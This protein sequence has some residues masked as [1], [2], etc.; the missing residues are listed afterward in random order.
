MR[1]TFVTLSIF[2]LIWSLPA[3]GAAAAKACSSVRALY[4]ELFE[5]A[6]TDA[7]FELTA[8][9]A[10]VGREDNMTSAELVVDDGTC[11]SVFGSTADPAVAAVRP[12]DV[13]RATGTI[14]EKHAGKR[15]ADVTSCSVLR[16]EKP[17]Q[18]HDATI[19]EILSGAH[20]FRFSRIRAIV[21]DAS[22]SETN[23]YWAILGLVD[24]Q[25]SIALQMLIEHGGADALDSLVGQEIL[26]DCFPAPN[27]TGLFFPGRHLRTY[28][29]NNLHTVA[30]D[31]RILPVRPVSGIAMRR[32]SDFH[33][34]G[35]HSASGYVLATWSNNQFLLKTSEGK[36]LR[37]FLHGDSTPR[38]G[39]SVEVVGFP[40][41]DFFCVNLVN[42]TWRKTGS[43]PCD[44][45]APAVSPLSRLFTGTPGHEH[46][47][48]DLH[49]RLVRIRGRILSV[50]NGKGNSQLLLTDE[51]KI[52]LVETA[53][54]TSVLPAL[55]VDA[56]IE[57][58]GVCV[59]DVEPWRSIRPSF[60]SVMIVPRS[61]SDL[62]ILSRPSPWTTRR[63]IAVI[64]A[65][66]AL[67][68]GMLVR[69]HLQKRRAA[70]LSKITT[71]LKVEERTRLAV[72][73]HDSLAQNLTGV[74][75]EID[76]AAKMA[77]AD[78]R[79]MC[80]HLETAAR[81]LK[82][83]RDE[84]RNCLWD[85]RNRALETAT[86]DEAIRQTL[87]PHVAG[88]DVA[89]RFAVPRERISDN[90]AHAI[91]RIVRELT[92][93]A[94]RHGKAAKIRIAGSVE[95]DRMLFSVRDD[96]CGFEPDKAPGFQEGHYGLLGIQERIDEF[97]GEFTLKSSPGNGTRAMVSLKMP[98]ET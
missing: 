88:V 27:D 8:R 16:H 40:E 13:I 87:A 35:L 97:E 28:G 29:T 98:Q 71:D 76:T 74:S 96:G 49:G 45:E 31:A 79:A 5:C 90:T 48:R 36:V 60:K 22:Q 47:D 57:V 1:G 38:A 3:T 86:M 51:G 75:L 43:R 44:G 52:L 84:L 14:R 15:Y 85:L 70:L 32:P 18:P 55:A 61:A 6:S 42:A 65:L 23:P 64:G 89:I 9:T 62:T 54:L 93:N 24:G 56:V 82:S 41:S 30:P 11:V 2:A 33:M 26:V 7:P 39:D 72:E 63:L 12:G 21:R 68:A 67:I 73:L 58:T 4:H 53:A 37:V 50:P 91:L 25:S 34:L 17:P 10:F 78:H 95:G 92:L 66:L 94:I 80:T 19:R 59:V 81:S 20:D 46:P 77:N 83:C 69:H